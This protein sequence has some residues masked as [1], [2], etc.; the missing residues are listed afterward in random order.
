MPTAT[1]NKGEQ[2]MSI[3]G[4]LKQNKNI[5]FVDK[6]PKFSKQTEENDEEDD[7]VITVNRSELVNK[8]D[9]EREKLRQV[10]RAEFDQ[11]KRERM[12]RMMP[13]KNDRAKNT[14][15]E[16]RCRSLLLKE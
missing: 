7:G 1:L 6:T 12:A 4:G 16:W 15:L 13:T 8:D 3:S 2:I 5:E 14:Y 11:E 9:Y 10:S